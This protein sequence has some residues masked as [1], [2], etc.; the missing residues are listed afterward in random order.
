MVVKTG[1]WSGA[2]V[3]GFDVI[4]DGVASFGQGGEAVV[5]NQLVFE[6]APKRLDESVIVTVALAS[7]GSDQALLS[8]HLA[9]RG[10]GELCATI[11][12]DDESLDRA[13]L[14]ERHT[15]SSDDK[16]GIEDLMHGQADDAAGEQIQDRDQIQPACALLL[17]G[18][19]MSLFSFAVRCA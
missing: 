11:G 12:V 5:I 1:V 17:R 3:E 8:Q 15:K 10:A 14:T 19:A 13:T 2:V 7:H 4:E 18:T 16:G 9:I 6:T